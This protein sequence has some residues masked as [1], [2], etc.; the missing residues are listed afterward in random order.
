M[1][2][3]VLIFGSTG[4]TKTVVLR[5]YNIVNN[6]VD[7][8]AFGDYQPE[9]LALGILPLFRIFGQVLLFGRLILD[10]AILFPETVSADSAL[11]C[12]EAFGVD[13]DERGRHSAHHGPYQRDHHPQRRESVRPSH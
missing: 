10:Y 3:A 12:V 4:K 9:D 8:A 6:L 2:P 5:Q 13:P 11:R 1:A 7:T